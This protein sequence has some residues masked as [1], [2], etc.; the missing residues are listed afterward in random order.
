[1][2]KF[3]IHKEPQHIKASRILVH[4]CNRGGNHPNLPYVHTGPA[5]DFAVSGYDPKK[6]KVGIVMRK[7]DPAK[8][9]RVL[10]HNLAFSSNSELCPPIFKDVADHAAIGGTHH[11]L[12][13][14]LWEAEMRS[15]ITG[16]VFSVTANPECKEDDDLPEVIANGHQYWVLSDEC[17]EAD[18]RLV[19]DYANAE[20]DKNLTTDQVIIFIM[21]IY[22]QH[23]PPITFPHHVTSLPEPP[24][25]VWL[26]AVHW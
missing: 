12:S 24:K 17:P 7:S 21:L 1:M 15:P 25:L 26:T 20:Q 10:N 22:F 11:A 8:W 23:L 2:D 4:Y 19:S 9:Q 18:L 3:S 14:R 5:E 6:P 13:V 16:R